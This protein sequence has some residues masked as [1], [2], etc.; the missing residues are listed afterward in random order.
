MPGAGHAHR[1]KAL[2]A[3]EHRGEQSPSAPARQHGRGLG[4]MWELAPPA[5]VQLPL[6]NT[7][8]MCQVLST[9]RDF[10]QDKS[11]QERERV[12]AP[13]PRLP[14]PS[15]PVPRVPFP[16]LTPCL[17]TCPCPA[18]ALTSRHAHAHALSAH[19][20]VCVRALGCHGLASRQPAGFCLP[21]ELERGGAGETEVGA[22]TSAPPPSRSCTPRPC[23]SAMPAA[24][25][26]GAE[27]LGPA[28]EGTRGQTPRAPRAAGV[29]QPL[30]PRRCRL[31][32]TAR[33]RLWGRAAGS[34]P[35]L[36]CMC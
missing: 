11:R 34:S 20:H 13:R 9:G 24:S 23:P 19:R 3:G 27:G 32:P 36:S 1:C 29:P 31:L 35:C 8:E 33:A 2:S 25:T 5:W 15:L 28:E 7:V 26:P 16:I 14:Q 17:M 18:S 22:P 4:T 30:P 12:A 21:R 6:C 10:P